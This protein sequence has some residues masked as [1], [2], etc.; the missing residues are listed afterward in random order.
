MFKEID[1]LARTIYGEARGENLETRLYIGW[2]IRNRVNGPAS[3][4]NTYEDVVTK[5][6]QFSSWNEGDPNHDDVMHP[7][8]S[9]WKV[10]QALAQAIYYASEEHNPI[11][12][13]YHYFDLTLDENPPS[14]AKAGSIFIIEAIPKIRFVKGVK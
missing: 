13:V 12:G 8:G 11:P 7:S 10:C 3:F 9:E 5:P 1:F 14:W 4:G 6:F 2:V